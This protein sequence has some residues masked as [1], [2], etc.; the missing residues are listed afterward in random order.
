MGFWN[1]Y[2]AVKDARTRRMEAEAR[3]DTLKREKQAKLHD[4]YSKVG[5][6]LTEAFLEPDEG[7]RN[8]VVDALIA[9]V[10]QL[11]GKPVSKSF[12]NWMRKNPDDA[13]AVLES[14]SQR[15]MSPAQLFE[16]GDDPLLLSQGLLALGR[17][18][19]EREARKLRSDG[20]G[21]AVTPPGP[22]SAAPAGPTP[23]GDEPL[24]TELS[25]IET[26]MSALNKRISGLASMGRNEAEIKPLRDEY[27]SLD[28]ARRKM[29]TAGPIAAVE[30]SSRLS[31]RPVDR[32]DLQHGVQAAQRAGRPDIAMRFVP[33]MRREAYDA[34]LN[35]LGV[36]TTQPQD[37][38]AAP[39]GSVAATPLPTQP[40]ATTPQG[41]LTPVQTQSDE[42]LERENIQRRTKPLSDEILRD[43]QVSRLGLKTVGEFEDAAAAGKVRLEDVGALARRRTLGSETAKAAVEHLEGIKKDG[44]SARAQ[45]RF[46]DVLAGAAEKAGPRGPWLTPLRQSANSLAQLVGIKNP[47]GMSNLQLMEAI[48]P[49]LAVLLSQQ[50]KGSQSDREFLAALATAPSTLNSEQGFAMLIYTAR[51]INDITKEYDIQARK[52]AAENGA[53]DAKNV[54]GRT[55]QEV[56]DDSLATFEK[57]NGTL[58]ERVSRAFGK[59]P[60]EL[61]RR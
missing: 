10:E 44:D 35:K 34:L 57:T 55:F 37:T 6:R 39:V 26:R 19:R 43:P 30:E 5:E 20:G 38:T 48:T 51:Q 28:E 27:N 18:K 7:I 12:T 22:S 9:E 54:N 14:A 3:M 56:W 4:R 29:R 21:A 52:W 36:N 49:K 24:S 45:S 42:L 2:T 47:T 17:A 1:S 8:T 25:T 32:A 46:L 60:K 31:V 59:S 41:S 33:G 40:A 58:Q 15:G 11:R 50:M 61:L 53:L 16:I 23:A 13:G